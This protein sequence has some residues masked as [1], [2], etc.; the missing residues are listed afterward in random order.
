M[1]RDIE[2]VL[3]PR[4]RIAERVREL[5]ARL[6]ADLTTA[7]AEDG[8]AEPEGHIV[9]LPIMTGAMVFTGDLIR[10]IP[11]KL[12]IELV[13]V[14]SY[15]GRSLE[16]KGAAMEAELPDTFEGRHVVVIDDIL[17]SG[18]T[19]QLVQRLIADRSPASVRTMVLLDKPARRAVEI[20]AD[21][22]GFEVPDEFVVG[23]GL[24]FDGYYRNLPDIATLRHDIT[25][26]EAPA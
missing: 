3:I 6:A 22:V 2:R 26:A 5:A 18:R 25:G 9:L 16:S 11:M 7:L 21:Y 10:E 20:K 19:M 17:D 14:T 24:D 13:A 1:R 12:S 4:Q 15:P 23:Y 8:V